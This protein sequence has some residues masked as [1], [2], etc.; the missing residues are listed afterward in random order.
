M[1]PVFEQTAPCHPIG[2]SGFAHLYPAASLG[3]IE[4]VVQVHHHG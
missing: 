2:G 4:L 1:Q 3:N